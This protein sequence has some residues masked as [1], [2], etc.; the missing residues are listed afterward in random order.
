M[1]NA[2]RL[3][4]FV[5]ILL[6]LVLFGGCETECEIKAKSYCVE[7]EACMDLSFYPRKIVDMALTAC[8]GCMKREM[9]R[10]ETRK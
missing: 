1:R 8:V 6:V 4:S 2:V 9:Y 3:Q 7:S 10:C 5:Y